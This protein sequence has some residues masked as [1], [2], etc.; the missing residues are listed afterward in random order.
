MDAIDYEQTLLEPN[1]SDWDTRR[2]EHEEAVRAGAV[3]TE[4]LPGKHSA[5]RGLDEPAITVAELLQRELGAV[6]LPQRGV[7]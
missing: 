7:A 2:A 3:W 1:G 5:T 4:R 6:H